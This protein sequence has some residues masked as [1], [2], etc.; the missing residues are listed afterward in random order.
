MSCATMFTALAAASAFIAAIFWFFAATAY[1]PAPH[2]D[3]DAVGT[4]WDGGVIVRAGRKGRQR[5]TLY[6]T[7][8]LQSRW[9][10]R[11]A[12]AAAASALASGAAWML[13]L[14]GS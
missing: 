14:I 11:G 12:L 3:D 13:P 5:A 2:R 1:V 9:N 4:L 7:L 10:A 8:E 6:E